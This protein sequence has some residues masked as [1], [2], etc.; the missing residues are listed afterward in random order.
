MASDAGFNFRSTLL[1]G[2]NKNTGSQMITGIFSYC[3]IIFIAYQG[4]IFC[5][6]HRSLNRDGL[7]PLPFHELCHG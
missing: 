7:H 1:D 3:Q 2:I 4:K 6:D 5:T